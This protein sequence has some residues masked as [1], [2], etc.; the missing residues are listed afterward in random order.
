MPVV[1]ATPSASEGLL[2]HISPG[3]SAL[4]AEL[5]NERSPG[6]YQQWQQLSLIGD[7]QLQQLQLHPESLHWHD[8]RQNPFRQSLRSNERTSLAKTLDTGHTGH[9]CSNPNRNGCEDKSIRT[10]HFS[11]QWM[12]VL[13]HWVQTDG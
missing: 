11:V 12:R 10:L 13:R 4:E 8:H 2:P 9:E 1:S 7:E 3:V 5:A 6:C